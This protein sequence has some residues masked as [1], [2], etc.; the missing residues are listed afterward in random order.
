MAMTHYRQ[1]RDH[2][3]V[4]YCR[5]STVDPKV[6]AMI[7]LCSRLPDAWHRIIMRSRSADARVSVKC[8][9]DL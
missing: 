5:V 1:S 6:L 4:S 3:N 2:H 7:W 9:C 8:G